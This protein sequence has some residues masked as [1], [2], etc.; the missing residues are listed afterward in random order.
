M[1]TLDREDVKKSYYFRD[2]NNGTQRLLLYDDGIVLYYRTDAPDDLRQHI[3]QFVA[4]M[5]M[6]QKAS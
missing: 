4:I 3:E 6:R 5:E 2:Q 1:E